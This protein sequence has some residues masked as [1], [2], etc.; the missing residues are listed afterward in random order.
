MGSQGGVKRVTIVI[1]TLDVGGT[2]TQ[3]ALLSEGLVSRGWSVEIFVLSSQGAL[4]PRLKKAGIR[5][6]DGG[7][8]SRSKSRLLWLMVLVRTG[9]KLTW[10]LC[11]SRPY[12]V[13]GFLPLTNFYAALAG[14][15]TWR[16]L[17][18]TSKRALGYHQDRH[19]KLKWLDLFSNRLSDTVTAN[20]RAVA[21]DT[22]RRDK[23]PIVDIKIIYNGLDF[24]RFEYASA[25]RNNQRKG[26]NLND[27]EVA[28]AIVA[29]IIE[30]KGH[31]DLL[32][33]FGIVVN[34]YPKCRLF[35][36]GDDRGI[37]DDL[38]AAIA[39]A[40][41]YQKIHFLDQRQDVPELLSAMDIGVLASHE[42]GLS[43]ALLEKL[44]AGLPVVV[45]DVGGNREAVEDMPN[46]LLARPKDPV[47]LARGLLEVIGSL[48]SDEPNRQ[49]RRLRVR[50]R[51]SVGAMIDSYEQL[52]LARSKNA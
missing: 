52:Y 18:V 42:E 15:L 32:K 28:I 23:Y 45:T 44:A 27:D 10:H 8:R 6:I 1:G 13:H 36:I 5:M 24:S 31:A 49:E 48:P 37:R 38:I 7:C 12:V 4:L 22:A 25:L 29:N 14:R 16:P 21:I 43:N 34:S 46:C 9:L 19:P 35:V 20:S 17:V 47:D 40:P 2:E 30:Y 39:E 26:L 51:F 11:R 50:K 41:W 33:A 3:V